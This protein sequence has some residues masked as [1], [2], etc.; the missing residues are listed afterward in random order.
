M[1]SRVN[2]VNDENLQDPPITNPGYANAIYSTHAENTV[3]M[4]NFIHHLVLN[5]Q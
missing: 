2:E 1:S 4:S 5:I 3:Q